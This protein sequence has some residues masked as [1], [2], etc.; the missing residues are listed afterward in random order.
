MS[1][2]NSGP[3]TYA[4]VLVARNRAYADSFEHAGH[5]VPPTQHIAIVACMDSRL[6]VPSLLGLEFGDAHVI[7]NA[8]GVVTDDVIR[9]LCVSQRKLGTR[10]IVLVHHTDCGLST[11]GEDS[12]RAEL[13]D[14][15][16]VTPTWPVEAFTDAHADVAQSM[17]RLRE[18][19]FVPYTDALRGFVFDVD[20]GLLDEVDG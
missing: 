10:E 9:S 11:I 7:R 13:L 17:R 3:T 4:D 6:D 2:S 14:E 20:T 16:G 15:L 19:P 8:G 18:S 1:T 12:F 5:Q